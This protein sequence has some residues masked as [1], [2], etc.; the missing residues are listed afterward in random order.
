MSPPARPAA[1]AWQG[2]GQAGTERFAELLHGL[3]F[4]PNSPTLMNAGTD[5][6]GAGD[7]PGRLAREAQGITVQRYGSRERQALT[8]VEDF[9]GGCAGKTCTY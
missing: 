2:I 4:L 3:D 8:Y 6:G 5:V 9:R 7:L 1:S